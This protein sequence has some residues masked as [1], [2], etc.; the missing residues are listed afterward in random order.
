MTVPVGDGMYRRLPGAHYDPEVIGN[1]PDDAAEQ[2]A[3]GKV[4][5]VLALPDPDAPGTFKAQWG[6][7]TLDVTEVLTGWGYDFGNNW[8]G[9]A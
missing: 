8:G 4:Y 6:L 5:A 1:I 3:L 7:L 9:G 2:L